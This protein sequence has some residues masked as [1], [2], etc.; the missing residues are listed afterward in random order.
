MAPP[1]TEVPWR[2]YYVQEENAL[3]VEAESRVNLAHSTDVGW[4]SEE[5]RGQRAAVAQI[6]GVVCKILG[7][8]E[9]L[10]TIACS[11]LVECPHLC[12]SPAS[13]DP[14]SRRQRSHSAERKVIPQRHVQR[15]LPACTQRVAPD[16]RRTIVEDA[17]AV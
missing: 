6:V 1:L 7:V 17:V 3:E 15:R 2:P 14:D 4:S 5:R 9:Q 8:H 13:K 12:S 11:S 10:Q 16:A